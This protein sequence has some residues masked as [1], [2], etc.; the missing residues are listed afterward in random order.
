MLKNRNKVA[1]SPKTDR[2]P[3]GKC[4]ALLVY[5]PGTKNLVCQY[6][7]QKNQIEDRFEII[8]EYDFHQALVELSL[9]KSTTDAPQIQ[10]DSCGASFKFAGTIN[11]GECPFCGSEVVLGVDQARPITP[12]SIL[13]FT[14]NEIEARECFRVWLKGLWFAPGTLKKMVDGDTRWQGVYIPYWT[15]DSQ[16]ETLYQGAKG[17]GLL[18]YRE[19]TLL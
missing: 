19:G 18:R 4:G 2:F 8:Q 17:K 13:P 12:K 10:C 1:G 3:C 14:L 7:G 5:T 15:Y 11:A 9:T 16:T 6:C